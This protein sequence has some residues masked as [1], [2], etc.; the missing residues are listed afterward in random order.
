M[1]ARQTFRR[2]LARSAETAPPD[3]P[4]AQGVKSASANSGLEHVGVRVTLNALT[5]GAYVTDSQ[6]TILFWSDAAASITGWRADEVVG[7]SCADGSG[8]RGALR[9]SAMPAS[10]RLWDR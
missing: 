4:A 1:K 8:R 7:R 3:V 5:Y 9:R 10:Q 6:R 2:L